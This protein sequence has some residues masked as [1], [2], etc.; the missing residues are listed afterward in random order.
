MPLNLASP[1]IIVREV[2][3]TSGRVDPSSNKIGA[4]AA[5]FQKGPINL[6]ILIESEQDLY[7]VFGGPL[8]IDKQYESWYV[9]SAYLSYGGSLRVLRS[10]DTDLKNASE[11]STAGIKILSAE[12]YNQLGYNEN[13][14]TSASIVARNP[15]SW[16]N[17]LKVCLIDSRA[18]QIFVGIATT[19]GIGTSLAIGMGVTQAITSTLPGIGTT[20][21]LDGYMKGM[22]TEIGQGSI[23]V[24]VLS[25]VSAGN[26]ETFVDY[27]PG[28]VY[29]FS[30]T[31]SVAIHTS[32]NTTGFGTTSYSSSSDWFESQYIQ[33][34]NGTK[35]YWNNIADKPST[36]NFGSE[37]LAR[38]DELHIL[39]IDDNGSITGNA[40]NILEKHL[41]LSKAT[42]AEFSAGS[43]SYWRRFLELNSRFI[44]GGKSPA[45]IATITYSADFT[46]SIDTGWDQR[47]ANVNFA[48]IGEKT[49][50]LGGGKNYNGQTGITTSGAMTASISKLSEAYT[51]LSNSDDYKIDFLL[52][53]SANYPKPEAQSLANKIISIAETRKDCLAFISPYRLGFVNDSAPGTVTV[54]SAATITDELVSFYSPIT[55]SSYAVFDSGY[56]YTYDRF[57]DTFRYIPL[58]GDIAGLCARTDINDFPW[59]SPAGTSRGNILNAIK[60]AYNPTQSQRDKLYSNRINPVVFSPGSGIV[61]FGDKT[62]L[63]KPSAFDRI[64][65]R[66]LFIYLQEAI[67]FAARDQLF[68]FNDEVTRTNFVN[69]VE[70]FLR[71]VQAKRGIQDF[72]VVCDETNNTAS[73]IDS[74]EFLA[75]IY[76][77]PARSIN[78]IGLTFIATRTGISF[79]EVIGTV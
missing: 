9:A 35:L 30:S 27:Q 71:D 26:T 47:A 12:N 62:A 34:S 45:G 17:D 73:V 74:N 32:G 54:N 64:N 68:E 57:N 44:F 51:V 53:G 14:I 78:F 38:F 50:V 37:R 67:T 72:R 49:I 75:D 15:G 8:P 66:R 48:C 7:S 31:G 33:I 4:I 10:D 52:M 11:P 24:K 61:L 39:I 70:P 5:P 46:P 18:D 1:G 3:L 13:I 63:A 25:H 58:N 41:G 43:P 56:K 16:A 76:V 21:S 79:E 55:S 2:D 23:S 22:I 20:S 36:T 42:D 40:G 60:L 59:F 65:V 28:G 77:Q 19:A 6:P 69:I 29:K